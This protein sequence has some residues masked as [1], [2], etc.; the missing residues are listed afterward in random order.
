M[1]I[2][3]PFLRRLCLVG[4]W[5]SFVAGAIGVF[6]P[7][8][9]TTPF[10]LLSAALWSRSSE[11][12]FVWLLTHKRLGPPIAGYRTSGVIPLR[13]KILAIA[14]IAASMGFAIIYVIPVL[15]GK[16]GMATIGISVSL[17][18][19]SRPSEAPSAQPGL[20]SASAPEDVAPTR[21]E[22]RPA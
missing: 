2:Q 5:V 18:L 15:P 6:L 11:R 7:V 8:L 1:R 3:N 13:A 12:F 20:E 21:S 22:S 16:I 4:G 10:L 9:P 17:W 14:M 19:L